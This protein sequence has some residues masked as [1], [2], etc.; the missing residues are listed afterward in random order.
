[1]TGRAVTLSRNGVVL[2]D[3]RKHEHD[4]NNLHPPRTCFYT[5]ADDGMPDIEQ[6]W[7]TP[8]V[9][10]EFANEAAEAIAAFSEKW[11]TETASSMDAAAT[12]R[13]LGEGAAI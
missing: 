5:L 10:R 2:L 13:G 8:R 3:T 11:A 1:M 7:A 4:G 9:R 12:L 6:T